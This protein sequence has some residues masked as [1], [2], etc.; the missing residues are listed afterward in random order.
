MARYW[1]GHDY[2]ARRGRLN[3][4]VEK[5]FFYAEPSKG[6]GLEVDRGRKI[7]TRNG[8]GRCE[9][10]GPQQQGA[11]VSS[12]GPPPSQGASRAFSGA[13][14]APTA[15]RQRGANPRCHDE[16]DAARSSPHPVRSGRASGEGH[17]AR[18]LTRLDG[19]IGS[20]EARGI[21]SASKISRKTA[22]V[23]N[24]VREGYVREGYMNSRG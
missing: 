22:P 20:R 11:D 1:N 3:S 24:Y 4:H 17:P 16:G 2:M 13:L 14:H 23:G 5:I 15:W 6:R 19:V 7:R 9:K 10:T 21:A 12:P 18:G 8:G